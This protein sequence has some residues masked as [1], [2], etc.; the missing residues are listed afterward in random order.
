ML[1]SNMIIWTPILEYHIIISLPNSKLSRSQPVTARKKKLIRISGEM[2]VNRN[3]N[4]S[5]MVISLSS[6][7]SQTSKNLFNIKMLSLRYTFTTGRAHYGQLISYCSVA[8]IMC[9]S[10]VFCPCF[11]MQY[12]VSNLVLQSFR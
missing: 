7:R 9:G 10:F 6:R 12:F 1:N 2:S 3:C 11:A 8:L 4:I 5:P